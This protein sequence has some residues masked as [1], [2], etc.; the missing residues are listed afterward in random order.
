[1]PRERLPNRRPNRT[2]DVVHD[3]AHYEVTIG[4]HPATGEAREVFCHG[5]KVGSTMD[6]ILDDICI[7]LSLLVQHGV[8]PPSLVATM[9][10]L[11]KGQ[12]RASIVGALADLLVA[13]G[14]RA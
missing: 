9:G 11:G 14:A 4:F 2:V 1:M 3:G 7:L 8:E 12:Q 13:V 6:G 10:R 5:A